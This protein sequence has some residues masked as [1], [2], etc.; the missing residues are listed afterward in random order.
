MGLIR[1]PLDVDFFLDPRPLTKKEQ[2]MISDFI[3]ADKEKR[4]TPQKKLIH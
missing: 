1:E 3:K 4:K 2:K